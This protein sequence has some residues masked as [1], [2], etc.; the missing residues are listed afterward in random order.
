[1]KKYVRRTGLACIILMAVTFGIPVNAMA[2]GMESMAVGTAVLSFYRDSSSVGK[3]SVS[4]ISTGT[5]EYLKA[6]ATLQY[7]E[8]NSNTYKNSSQAKVTKTVYNTRSLKKYFSFSISTGK[9]Y[10]IKTVISDKI[11]GVVSTKTYYKNMT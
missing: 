9:K 7:A 8:K 11:N 5:P 10:R 2:V 3:G 6:T 1:M 4:V